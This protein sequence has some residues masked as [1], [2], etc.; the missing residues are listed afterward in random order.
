MSDSSDP[1]GLAFPNENHVEFHIVCG[2]CLEATQ[3]NI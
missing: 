2:T 1:V 3:K